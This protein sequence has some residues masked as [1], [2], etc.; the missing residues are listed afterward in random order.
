LPVSN[1]VLVARVARGSPA[2]R[3]G[4]RGA[5]QQ[6]IVGNQ[7]V[8]AGGDIVTAIDGQPV[9]SSRDLDRY[10]ELQTRVGQVVRLT[11]LRD[12]LEL[13]LSLELMERP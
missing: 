11:V 7:R 3:A 10:V 4:L 2:A 5:T 9:T 8:L 13:T 6:V 12:G 1:G